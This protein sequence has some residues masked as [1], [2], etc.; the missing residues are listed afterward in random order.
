MD[1][2]LFAART[3]YSSS[4]NSG[5]DIIDITVYPVAKEIA[6]P[7]ED[8]TSPIETSYAYAWYTDTV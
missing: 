1:F 4:S 7:K 8:G 2:A 6:Y 3:G 5:G